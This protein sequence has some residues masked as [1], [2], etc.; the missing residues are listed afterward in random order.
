MVQ[1]LN[2]SLIFF[3]VILQINAQKV[4][5][6][7]KFINYYLKSPQVCY[8][9][10][11]QNTEVP[12]IVT[13]L[14][15]PIESYNVTTEDNYILTVFR[16]PQPGA[17]PIFLQHG[18]ALSAI[19]F[20][21]TLES[22]LG[23]FRGN[24]YSNKHVTLDPNTEE[25]WNFSFHEMGK[26]DLKA[27]LGLVYNETGKKIYYV[28]YSMGTTASYIYNILHPEDASEKLDIIVSLAPIVYMKNIPSSVAQIAPLWPLIEPLVTK[29]THGV[30]LQRSNVSI[31]LIKT[32]CLGNLFEMFACQ[33][34]I[35]S[36]F[37]Y[38]NDQLN[39]ETLP[40]TMVQ[41]MEAISTKTISHY[42]QFILY[43]KFSYFKFNEET[44][45]QIYGNAIPPLY[46]I[47]SLN[48]PIYLMYGS[49]DFFST[50]KNVD[51]FFN[52]LPEDT[53][54]N[55]KYLV[56]LKK[57]NH[58]DFITAKDIKSLVYDP[59]IKFLNNSILQS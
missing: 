22:S 14:G 57:F 18:I 35:Q 10:P 40:V 58:A 21:D 34:L 8:Y 31:N 25:Y 13:R 19:C 7:K 20:V 2:L 24:R 27:Q 44:N 45:K 54:Q 52:E 55:G 49:N 23:N 29:L 56:Q 38:D 32:L 4:N 30:I 53:K 41:N 51:K 3:C 6:C 11:D 43:G 15:Y 33:A 48:V 50:I 28:G 39:P 36:L 26:F 9:N 1:V 5:V 46:N 12:D 17:K 47:S 59:L 37:G 42:V 16:L